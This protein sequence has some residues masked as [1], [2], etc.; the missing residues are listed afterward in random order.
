MGDPVLAAY[1]AK[2]KPPPPMKR[3]IQ[4]EL[5]VTAMNVDKFKPGERVVRLACGHAAVTRAR[6]KCAC[7]ECHRMIMDGEDYEQF[8]GK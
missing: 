4:T 3:I 2:L 8:R 1:M 7:K 6:V 5:I